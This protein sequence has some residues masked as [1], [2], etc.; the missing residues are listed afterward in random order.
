MP[1]RVSALQHIRREY[2]RAALVSHLSD[3]EIDYLLRCPAAL[4]GMRPCEHPDRVKHGRHEWYIVGGTASL[5]RACGA[6]AAGSD[7]AHPES[8]AVQP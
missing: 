6:V 4:R 7:G 8:A 5:C 1:A 3:D 2:G